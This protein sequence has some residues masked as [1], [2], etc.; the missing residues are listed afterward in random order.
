MHCLATNIDLRD[1]LT[2][3]PWPDRH[4]V[5][6]INR[7]A[8]PSVITPQLEKARCGRF[9][10][11]QDNAIVYQRPLVGQETNHTREDFF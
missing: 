11:W 8:S 1:P 3:P 2:L 9:L 4:A 7:I 10:P 5:P 6:A